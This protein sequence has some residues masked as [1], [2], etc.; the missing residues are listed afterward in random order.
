MTQVLSLPAS[1]SFRSRVGAGEIT[2]MT[3]RPSYM[4]GRRTRTGRY[5]RLAHVH[6]FPPP[7]FI[8]SRCSARSRAVCFRAGGTDVAYHV[9]SLLAERHT[10]AS[11][12]SV[13]FAGGLLASLVEWL[14]SPSPSV[15]PVMRGW[16]WPRLPRHSLLVTC[17]RRGTV[18]SW[19]PLCFA[20]LRSA[21]LVLVL[22]PSPSSLPRRTYTHTHTQSIYIYMPGGKEVG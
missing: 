6:G 1:L 22:R 7:G 4:N 3:G 14:S 16:F 5:T 18:M 13:L 15:G 9:P 8:S 10:Q 17:C 11:S 21:L 2:A 20:L 12:L 19:Q